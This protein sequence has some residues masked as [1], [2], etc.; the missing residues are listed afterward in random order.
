MTQTV[1]ACCECGD[2]ITS[3]DFRTGADRGDGIRRHWHDACLDTGTAPETVALRD[4]LE[5]SASTVDYFTGPDQ[6]SLQSTGPAPSLRWWL[7]LLLRGMLR[8]GRDRLTRTGGPTVTYCAAVVVVVSAV[9]LLAGCG[10]SSGELDERQALAAAEM[11]WCHASGGTFS[12]SVHTIDGRHVLG[13]ARTGGRCEFPPPAG[14]DC[15]TTADTAAADTPVGVNWY[16][17][18]LLAADG[19]GE[20][21]DVYAHCKQFAVVQ[22]GGSG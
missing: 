3:R 7:G 17:V 2:A 22:A 14:D 20:G 11:R 5:G 6:G 13:L 1:A 9:V 21:L 12:D 18:Y 16:A 8:R 10:W 4:V 15:Y 19:G